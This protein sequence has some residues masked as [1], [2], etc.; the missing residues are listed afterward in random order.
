MGPLFIAFGVTAVLLST[1]FLFL[2]FNA[3]D[4]GIS[5]SLLQRLREQRARPIPSIIHQT[6]SS[7]SVPS[8]ASACMRSWA[9]LNPGY[10]I[11]LWT[12]AA[13]LRLIRA[14]YPALHAV[15]HLLK[16]VEKGDATRYAVVHALGGV[17]ADVDVKCKVPI[18]DWP[19][20]DNHSAVLGY[21]AILD[22]EEERVHV[23]MPDL[24]PI[25]QWTFAAAPRHWV[26][27]NAIDIVVENV[28]ANVTETIDRTGP[29]AF[30][31]AVKRGS[32]RQR[33]GI[34]ILP[35][36]AFAT[37]GYKNTMF[38]ALDTLVLHRFR[39]SWKTERSDW[40]S[41]SCSSLS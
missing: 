16:P 17:Y 22:S 9:S 8:W 33:R 30:T 24:A 23:Q 21:E 35:P 39:G 15:W 36:I 5:P 32:P 11:H 27:K 2:T 25:C 14:R 4:D 18:D 13:S 20:L 40:K 37:G 41:T 6:W 29:G 1:F 34:K 26:M 12:D 10:G 7:R 28:N 3:D 31:K 38:S 19:G